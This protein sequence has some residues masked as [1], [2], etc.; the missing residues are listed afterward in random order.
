MSKVGGAR[1][2]SGRKPGSLN[3]KSVALA[4]DILGSSKSPLEYLMEVM[5][6]EATDEKRRDWAAEKAAAFIHPRPAPIQR[7]ITIELPAIA[8]ARDIPAA[9]SSIFAA[10]SNGEISPG[11]A[12]SLVSIIDSQRK[13]IETGELLER[14]ER[15]EALQSP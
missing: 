12:Q 9:V 15:L 13:A 3:Q 6:D 8:T 10:A 11:E 5:M 14:L 4:A 1:P 7:T 2:G